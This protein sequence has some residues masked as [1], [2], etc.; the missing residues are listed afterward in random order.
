M[1]LRKTAAA[2]T[3]PYLEDTRPAGKNATYR[4]NGVTDFDLTLKEHVQ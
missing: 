3:M 2:L 1:E 4:K